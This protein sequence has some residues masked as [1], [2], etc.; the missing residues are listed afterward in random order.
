[1]NASADP[2][3]RHIYVHIGS[4]MGGSTVRMEW[5]PQKLMGK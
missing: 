5:Q 1:M 4:L 3:R 2:L